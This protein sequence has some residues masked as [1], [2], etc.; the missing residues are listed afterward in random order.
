MGLALRWA[1]AST[2]VV[3]I[4]AGVIAILNRRKRAAVPEVLKH[5]ERLDEMLDPTDDA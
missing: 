2:V 4:V 5:P 1:L 3:A